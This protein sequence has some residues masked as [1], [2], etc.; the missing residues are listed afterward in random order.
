MS[1]IRR[2]SIFDVPDAWIHPFQG[3][4]SPAQRESTENENERNHRLEQN[5]LQHMA[6][7]TAACNDDKQS[8]G[9]TLLLQSLL[10]I[11][12]MGTLCPISLQIKHLS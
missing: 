7:C 10:E 3:A 12:E 4:T 8:S 11:D 9:D 6:N 2:L 5:K 1:L